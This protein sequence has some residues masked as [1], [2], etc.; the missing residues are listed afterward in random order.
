MFKKL[1]VNEYLSNFTC[2]LT[3][4]LTKNV[5]TNFNKVKTLFKQV[6]VKTIKF[7]IMLFNCVSFFSNSKIFYLVSS[8][9]NFS[10]TQILQI[11]KICVNE[12]G[13][14]QLII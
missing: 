9:F 8:S 1:Y 4:R 5:T 11:N 7:D 2:R 6:K 12:S 14:S 13:L 10:F 3:H